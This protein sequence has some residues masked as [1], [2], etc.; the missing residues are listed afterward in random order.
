M[1]LLDFNIDYDDFNSQEQREVSL[2]Y[3]DLCCKAIED[4]TGI[5]RN[6]WMTNNNRDD[7]VCYAWRNIFIYSLHTIFNF[8][9]HLVGSHVRMSVAGVRAIVHKIENSRDK[10]DRLRLSKIYNYIEKHY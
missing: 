9:L 6:E 10:K 4:I 8:P 3:V 5:H 2:E 7:K 1:R